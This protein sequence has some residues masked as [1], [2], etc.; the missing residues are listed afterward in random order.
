MLS[1]RKTASTEF[2]REYL[3]T[4]TFDPSFSNRIN[5]LLKSFGRK[6]VTNLDIDYL[7]KNAVFPDKAAE[8]ETIFWKGKNKYVVKNP[9]TSGESDFGFYDDASNTAEAIL[10]L[11]YNMS[12]YLHDSNS[13]IGTITIKEYD[14]DKKTVLRK[15]ELLTCHITDVKHGNRDKGSSETSYI[16]AHITWDDSRIYSN[17][18]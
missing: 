10:T 8:F 12:A 4:M 5:T 17:K 18:D 14:V 2:K 6:P 16:N 13:S 9:N 1:I 11:L 15:A 7:N 3:Y